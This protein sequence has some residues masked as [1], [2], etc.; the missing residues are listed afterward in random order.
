MMRRNRRK[1]VA[2]GGYALASGL[3]AAATLF[4]AIWRVLLW[5]ILDPLIYVSLGRLTTL[6][7]LPAMQVRLDFTAITIALSQA[8][9]VATVVLLGFREKTVRRKKFWLY[10]IPILAFLLVA[11]LSRYWSITPASTIKRSLY[12]WAVT[13]GGIFIGLEYRRPKIVLIYEVLSV[14]LVIGSLALIAKYPNPAIDTEY[15]IAGA[16]RGMLKYKGYAGTIMAFAG[17]IFLLRIS[18]WKRLG[19]PGRAYGLAFLGLCLLLV[20]KSK[21]ATGQ[22]AFVGAAGVFLLGVAWLRWGDRLQPRHW[23]AIALVVACLIP[24]A[25]ISIPVLFGLFG[26][27]ISLTGRVPL[28][29]T[30]VPFFKAK[31]VFGWGF[32]D[33]FWLSDEVEKVW[34]VITWKPG[35]A[36]SGLVE[37]LLDTGLA[38]LAALTGFLA[39][40]SALT[41]AYIRSRRS[42]GPLIFLVWLALVVLVNLG[43]NLLGT[44]ELFFWLALVVVFAHTAKEAIE[45]KGETQS[46][47]TMAD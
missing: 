38:G 35:T 25:L 46:L 4:V 9:L 3:V 11:G 39:I 8:I 20:Y 31:P 13:L 29:K 22:I 33:A 26:R 7:R 17:T 45:R 1:T 15:D 42:V 28:W 36:H 6:L 2:R 37:V 16:W 34:Q 23:K 5:Q 21:S 24:I 10:C 12:L 47:S 30:L 27:D 32:G 19:W 43:E 41:V 44:Y 40:T 18:Q 14:L